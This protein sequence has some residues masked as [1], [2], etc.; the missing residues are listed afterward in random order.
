MTLE[1]KKSTK[2]TDTRKNTNV[3]RNRLQKV[4]TKA[5]PNE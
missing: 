1:G 2:N 4:Q 5:D 3:Y